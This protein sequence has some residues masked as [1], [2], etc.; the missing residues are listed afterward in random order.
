MNNRTIARQIV[1]ELVDG[2][3]NFKYGGIVV[4]IDGGEPAKPE[5]RECDAFKVPDDVNVD[6]YT[7]DEFGCDDTEGIINFCRSLRSG[8]LGQ[9]LGKA[10]VQFF[11]LDGREEPEVLTPEH[12]GATLIYNQE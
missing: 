2:D 9:P 11:G 6:P 12:A 4:I 8:E 10:K 3:D 1:E 7:C 5:I